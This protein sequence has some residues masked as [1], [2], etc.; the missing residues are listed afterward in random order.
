[1]FCSLAEMRRHRPFTA[2][3][4]TA[5]LFAACLGI[6][7]SCQSECAAPQSLAAA[8]RV[9]TALKLEPNNANAIKL[10]RNLAATARQPQP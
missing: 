5:G 2:M 7:A 9:A 1:V 6:E 10:G 4:T 8:V 3:A